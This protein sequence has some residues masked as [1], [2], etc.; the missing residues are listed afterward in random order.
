M[1]N[2]TNSEFDENIKIK[3][4]ELIRNHQLNAQKILILGKK[5]F[6]HLLKLDAKIKLGHGCKIFKYIEKLIQ[7]PSIQINDQS[8]VLSSI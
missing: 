6:V 7:D 4:E 1:N 5:K 3:I 8:F 2:H